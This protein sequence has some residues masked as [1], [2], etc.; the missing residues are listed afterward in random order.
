MHLSPSLKMLHLFCNAT[1]FQP[2]SLFCAIL[3]QSIVNILGI[4]EM[5]DGP[6]LPESSL[7]HRKELDRKSQGWGWSDKHSCHYMST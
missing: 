5:K 2:F 1:V 4:W 3:E 6:K 7:V